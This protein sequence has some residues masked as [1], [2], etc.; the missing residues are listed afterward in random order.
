MIEVEEILDRWIDKVVVE[1]G[2]PTVYVPAMYWWSDGSERVVWRCLTEEQYAVRISC[3][4]DPI[5]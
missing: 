1:A 3:L 4:Y 5:P 2:A